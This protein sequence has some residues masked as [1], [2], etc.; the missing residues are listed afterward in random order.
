MLSILSYLR[1]GEYLLA[2]ISILSSCFV[3]F[4]CLPVHELAH[5]WVAYKLGDTTAKDEG[6]LTFNPLAHLNPIHH[7][8]LSLWD[9]LCSPYAGESQSL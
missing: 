9:W 1:Q 7:Y 8:D 5:G 6:R 4:C 2:L 3:V